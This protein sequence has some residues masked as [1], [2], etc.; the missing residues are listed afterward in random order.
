MAHTSALRAALG[1]ALVALALTACSTPD[2]PQAEPA[3][4]SSGGSASGGAAAGGGTYNLPLVSPQGDIDPLTVADFNAMFLV[5]L[6]NA[7]LV[8]KDPEGQLVGQLASEW[9]ASEDGLTW[10]VQLRPG[11]EFSNGEP[12]TPA[13]VVWTFEQII[14]PD[15]V[16]PAASSFDGTLASVAPSASGDAVDFTL[17]AAYSDFPYLLSGANTWIL[18]EGTDTSTW[19]DDPVGAGQF[20]LEDYTPG[21]G[22]TYAKNPNYWDADAV[23]LDGIQAKFFNDVQS[24]QLAF[25]SG[26]VD[27][28]AN[29][30][31]K[32]LGSTPHRT[33]TAGWEKFDG[34]V[35]DTTQ[36]PFDDVKVR[37][38]IAAV[39][40]RDAIVESV[41]QGDAEVANDVATFPDYEV[42]P[43]GLDQRSADVDAAEQLLDGIDTPISFTITT[44]GSE[45]TLAQ[46]IQQQL[47]AT[48]LFDVEL[49]VQ[50]SGAYY[51]TGDN[52]PWLSA[53][54]TIT[55]WADRLPSQLEALLYAEGAEWNAGRYTNPE[56]DDLTAQYDATT[57]A[58]QRQQLADQ[59]AT[60]QHEDVPVVIA[61]FVKSI[62]QLGPR[63][64][65]SF[66]N[67]QKFDGGFDFRG[68]TVTG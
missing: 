15:S 7:Q 36:A 8:N 62:V 30:S 16:S 64:D 6:A 55:D 5:G 57:D 28:L 37:Q 4:G 27:Q 59:I 24:Q 20:T 68:I 47:E 1:T 23:Q 38:A 31:E 12:V 48:G 67:G 34:L 39:L 33:D 52:S 32:Q 54:V 11:I 65:G 35:F 13:D 58:A 29:V 3:G 25:Q 22:A 9:S 43:Q 49:D 61:A 60:I 50:S 21:T 53:P 42:Q 2:N 51:A 26:E 19:I 63:V 40:D 56:L 45:E 46:V 41:Y 17:D 66:A 10:T 18:P 14:A 44:Y